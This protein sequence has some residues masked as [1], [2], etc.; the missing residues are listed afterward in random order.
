MTKRSFFK[1]LAGAFL[2]SAMELGLI[3]HE[4]VFNPG[5]PWDVATQMDRM[6][7]EMEFH[8]LN[9]LIGRD[10]RPSVD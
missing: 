5:P 9:L 3:V 4:P 6:F 10:D 7:L 2:A 1:S 8:L